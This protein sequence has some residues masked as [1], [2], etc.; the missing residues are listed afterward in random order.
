M[1]LEAFIKYITYEKRFSK[2]TIVSYK[3]DLHQFLSFLDE[4]YKVE[5]F[6]VKTDM[7]RSWVASLLNSGISERTVNRKV[8]SLRS[9]FKY[10]LRNNLVELNPVETISALK[11]AKRLPSYVRKSELDQLLSEGFFEDSFFGIRDKCILYLFFFTGIRL[12]EL[13]NIKDAD[14]SI[15]SLKV[16]GKRNK[17]RIVPLSPTLI[18]LLATY[19]EV[20]DSENYQKVGFLLV[21]DKGDKLYEKFVFRK[22]KHYLSLITTQ[23]KKSPH[24]LRHTFATQ[25]LDNGADLNA[26][27]ELLGH[28]D[29]SATQ[30]YTHNSIEKLKVVYKQAHPRSGE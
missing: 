17:E 14:L 28:S 6:Q 24:V 2:H 12:S 18:R 25:M 5:L 22:V 21:T 27:K 10:L 9:F 8:S 30:V 3:V 15:N 7:V 4:T 13:I 23:E 26:I 1:Q 19:R 11:T 29:L 16:L 20:R